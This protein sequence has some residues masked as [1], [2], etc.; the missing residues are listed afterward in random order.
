MLRD[1]VG[2]VCCCFSCLRIGKNLS[3]FK[4]QY[5]RSKREGEVAERGQGDHPWNKVRMK[6]KQHGMFSGRTALPF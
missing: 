3:T 5:M 4:C 2:Y 1:T 6:L